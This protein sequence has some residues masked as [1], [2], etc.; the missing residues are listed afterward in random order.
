[1]PGTTLAFALT[2]SALSGPSDSNV[3][4]GKTDGAQKPAEI[5]AT[6]V[7]EKIT[8]YQEIK[9][10]GLKKEDPEYWVLLNKANEKFYAAVKKVAEEKKYDVVTEK[11]SVKFDGKDPPDIT[12]NVID[13]LEK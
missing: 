8:E 7:F 1:M 5:V 2:L 9:K 3:Y 13:A 4:F 12:Q 11:G 10:R 6:T